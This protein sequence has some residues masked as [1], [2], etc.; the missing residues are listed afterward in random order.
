MLLT[1]SSCFDLNL[2]GQTLTETDTRTDTD[3]QCQER[4]SYAEYSYQIDLQS[5]TIILD[6]SNS[7]Y[8]NC[9]LTGQF[10]NFQWDLGDGTSVNA[11]T[12]L[13][14][15]T[16]NDKGIYSVEL[17]VTHQGLSS[18]HIQSID[19]HSQDV[20]CTEIVSNP[21]FTSTLEL[22][23]S[24]TF[25]ASDSV[26]YENCEYVDIK[27]YVWDFGD[28]NS[29]TTTTATTSHIYSL[30]DSDSDH[31][32]KLT[33]IGDMQTYSV[34]KLI[35]SFIETQCDIYPSTYFIS[36]IKDGYA[37]FDASNAKVYTNNLCSNYAAVEY[38][39][40]FGDGQYE[41]T[42]EALISH[43]YE[44]EGSYDVV[45]NA[46]SSNGLT[47][48]FYQTLDVDLTDIC[49]PSES[50][51][52]FDIY[53]SGGIDVDATLIL[54][55][56]SKLGA[57]CNASEYTWNFGDGT[58]AT[59]N[60]AFITHQYSQVG[61]YDILVTNSLGHSFSKSVKWN[62]QLCVTDGYPKCAVISGGYE[63]VVAPRFEG[64]ADATFEISDTTDS[65]DD[66][67]YQWQT[68]DGQAFTGQSFDAVFTQSG[69]SKI[70]VT[71]KNEGTT[72]WSN[73]L[74]YEIREGQC[75]NPDFNPQWTSRN[76]YNVND[77]W[78]WEYT[79]A[80]P[81]PQPHFRNVEINGF[82]VMFNADDYLWDGCD[83][84]DIIIWDF[85]DGT[86]LFSS[87]KT[88]THEYE[89]AGE[90]VVT[91]DGNYGFDQRTIIIE[92]E[93][94]CLALPNPQFEIQSTDGLSVTLN[95]QASTSCANYEYQWDFGDGYVLDGIDAIQAH[96][97]QQAGTYRITL[98]LTGTDEE[99]TQ[100]VKVDTT[101]KNEIIINQ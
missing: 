89:L 79:V 72:I 29:A 80:P 69:D 1:L 22:N 28:G 101:V 48:E 52:M 6:A 59:T 35:E 100:T 74:S 2:A 51:L 12:P 30:N 50:D 21:T 62:D 11:S 14:E 32:V 47:A 82:N 66:H 67:T 73:L 86:R 53:T 8:D 87:D 71:V 49:V 7:F 17:S 39:W 64:S 5:N 68:S 15:Y 9:S 45:L 54:D 60:S 88:I 78:Y 65:A 93:I 26:I 4:F 77:D 70:L 98:S 18:T 61:E 19:V 37:N 76:Q 36:G 34:T 3:T 96:Q 55:V 90:Y 63:V 16:Y 10:D 40:D 13:T 95:A 94:M 83:M 75:F 24:H 31:D 27:E 25:D 23:G 41:V 85:G 56:S 57:H 42:N 97:F 91:M 46:I 43:H 38:Q 84:H 81:P 20:N 44:Q 58:T 99:F 33:I 92:P